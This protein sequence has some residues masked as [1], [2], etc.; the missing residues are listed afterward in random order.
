METEAHF[1]QD[2]QANFIASSLQFPFN[3][4]AGISE[5]LLRN[6]ENGPSLCLYQEL[7]AR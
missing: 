5:S 6:T 7:N 2:F 4:L 1:R 3:E